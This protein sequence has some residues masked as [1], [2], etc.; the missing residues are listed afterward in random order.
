[1]ATNSKDLM[2]NLD[3]LD[4]AATVYQEAAAELK[5]QNTVLKGQIDSQVSEYW[6]SAAGEAFYSDYTDTWEP[7]LLKCITALEDL[8]SALQQARDNYEEVQM[9]AESIKF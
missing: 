3:Q 5:K 8:S 1:M 2:F 4:K 7:V 6:Q 9:K